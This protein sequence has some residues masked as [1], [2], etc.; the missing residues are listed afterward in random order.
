M[1]SL[2]TGIRNLTISGFFF[3][4]PIIVIFILVAKVWKGLTSIGTRIAATFG[5]TS[6][7]G[8]K[9]SHLIAGLLILTTCFLCG[10]LVR[11]SF[12]AAFSNLVERCMSKYVPGYEGYKA[13]AEEKLQ[14]R[15]D[16]YPMPVL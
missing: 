12:V 8:F 3:L 1:K 14:T 5:V 13:V 4:L 2:F 6:I 9:G 16:F 7:A 15:P 10:L 11:V